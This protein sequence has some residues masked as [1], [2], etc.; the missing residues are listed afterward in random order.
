MSRDIVI[1]FRLPNHKQNYEDDGYTCYENRSFCEF[2]DF[3]IL[4]YDM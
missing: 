1:T 3:V 2:I 4:Q